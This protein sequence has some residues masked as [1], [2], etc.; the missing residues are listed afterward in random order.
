VDGVSV[1]D[2]GGAGT[3]WGGR[4][5]VRGSGT[6]ASGK[7]KG[8]SK[9]GLTVRAANRRRTWRRQP[10]GGSVPV[11][12]GVAF[13]RSACPRAPPTWSMAFPPSWSAAEGADTGESPGSRTARFASGDRDHCRTN[14]LDCPA[15]G[16]PTKIQSSNG[17]ETS[18]TGARTSVSARCVRIRE[19]PSVGGAHRP[20]RRPPAACLSGKPSPRGTS[21]S[22]HPR[23]GPMND[24]RRTTPY[25]KLG[26]TEPRTAV[27]A[28]WALILKNPIPEADEQQGSAR[29]P[30]LLP[31]RHPFGPT[32]SWLSV[33]RP[34]DTTG[35]LAPR[36]CFSPALDRVS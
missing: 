18:V 21:P 2:E 16:P 17:S 22:T 24:K 19:Q 36:S 26:A 15:A 23:P 3:G 10:H 7:S 4:A 27:S 25:S 13:E 28:R 33:A 20:Q 1:V 11:A 12:A 35:Q 34:P 32:S 5:R 30:G 31:T 6:G 14:L 29:D 8:G 9:R